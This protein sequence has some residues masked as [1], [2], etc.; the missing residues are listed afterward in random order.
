MPIFEVCQPCKVRYN[1]YGKFD[2]LRRDAEVLMNHVGGN[3]SLLD[4]GYYKTTGEVSSILAPQYYKLLTEKQKIEVIRK[5]AV[6]LLF[7]Y[8]IF[9]EEK[10][11]HKV[12]M[13]TDI[14]LQEPIS[15]A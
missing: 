5:L 14:E 15:R 13:G 2:T 4:G 3:L 12:T 6:D 1:Y 10:D 11:A 8:S 9:P 7:Y